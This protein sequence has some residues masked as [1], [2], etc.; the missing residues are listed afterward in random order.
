MLIRRD[1]TPV[2]E[3]EAFWDIRRAGRAMPSRKDFIAEDF[4][5]WFGHIRLLAVEHDPLRF[6]VT[7]EGT[8]IRDL[9]GED[10]TGRYLDDA[11][12]AAYREILLAPYQACVAARE[13]RLE[14]LSP[15][16]ALQNFT[17]LERLMLPCGEDDRVT[18]LIV[19]IYAHGFRRD[20]GT[21]YRD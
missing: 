7:L 19:A 12:K 9:A 16:M 8:A 15:G 1:L 17:A 11:Y 21:I 6:K 18:H 20:A 14:A 3:L 2:S 10:F 5:P 4:R 13:P